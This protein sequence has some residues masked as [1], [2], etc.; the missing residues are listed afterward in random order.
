MVGGKCVCGSTID[1]VDI[2][3]RHLLT[4][5]SAHYMIVWLAWL[6]Y[7]QERRQDEV[8]LQWP[9]LWT[10]LPAIHRR[11]AKEHTT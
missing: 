2:S 6:R 5:L 10:S 8:Y 9:S 7:Y 4:A 1:N 3:C 11:D